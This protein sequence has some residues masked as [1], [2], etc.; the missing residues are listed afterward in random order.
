M[1]KVLVG[2]RPLSAIRPS[3]Q[4][5]VAEFGAVEPQGQQFGTA[6]VDEGL[7]AGGVE[8]DRRLRH[9]MGG[10]RI[11]EVQVDDH[12]RDD[13]LGGPGF[14]LGVPQAQRCRAPSVVLVQTRYVS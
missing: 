11:G 3:C 10:A 6:E 13:Q 1:T 4:P 12:L 7:R 2:A 8:V 14:G 9:E 5:V